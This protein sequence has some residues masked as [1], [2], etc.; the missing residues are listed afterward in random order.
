MA[1]TTEQHPHL[2]SQPLAGYTVAVTADRRANEQIEL[3]TR[4][5]ATVIH[6]PTIRTYPLGDEGGLAAASRSIIAEPPD[7][8]VLL[9]A[10]GVRSWLEAAEALDLAEEL[11]GV[12]AT[13]QLWVR[14]PKAK[15]AAA[16]LGLDP[17]WT[18]PVRS[19]ELAEELLARGVAGKRVAVQLDG[20]GNT[21][22]LDRLRRAGAD[23]LPVPIYRWSLPEDLKPA[24]RLVR[25]LA[26]G[27]VDAVTFTTQTAVVHLLDIARRI[28][29]VDQATRAFAAGTLAVCVG[30]VCAERARSLGF[31]NV[32]EPRRA[33]LGSMVH[34]LADRM[35]PDLRVVSTGARVLEIRGRMVSI[36]GTRVLLTERERDTLRALVD[37][38]GRVLTK[39]E[40][41]RRVW[42]PGEQDTHLVEVTVGRLRQRLGAAGDV[43]ET[44]FRRGYRLAR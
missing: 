40:L 37:A 19:S 21:P 26:D 22:L 6:A 13:T 25:L 4:K 3:L 15:G 1:L 39:A 16:A 42:G 44:V 12:L 31:V 35:A 29:L 20:A 9:T 10:L 24:E 36:D 17:A 33:R 2:G 8:V 43:V 7:I 30:P 18:A 11:L 34:E 41:L 32:I 5:G 14:G 38:D 28:G 27:R 23:V